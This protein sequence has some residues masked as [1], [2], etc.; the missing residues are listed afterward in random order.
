MRLFGTNHNTTPEIESTALA[1]I[2]HR[3]Y[4]TFPEPEKT[5]ADKARFQQ[6]RFGLFA[7]MVNAQI[8]Y[9]LTETERLSALTEAAILKRLGASVPSEPKTTAQP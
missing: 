7:K 8:A 2:K 9:S 1:P 5:S 4:G 6:E 3:S